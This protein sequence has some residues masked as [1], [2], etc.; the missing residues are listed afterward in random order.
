MASRSLDE[1]ERACVVEPGSTIHRMDRRQPHHPT[2]FECCGVRVDS[3]ELHEAAQRL[4]AAAAAEHPL[5]V[6]LCNASTLSLAQRDANFRALLNAGN[7]NLPDGTPVAWAGRLMACGSGRPVPGPSLM[8]AVFQLDGGGVQHFLLGS[9]PQVLTAL[10][11]ALARRYPTARI[12]GDFSPK[13]TPDVDALVIESSSFVRASGATLVWVGL[14]TPK[15][16]WV[17]ARLAQELG[18]V[19]VPVGAAFDFL[20]GS[21]REAP[22][23]LRGS[24]LEWIFRLATEPRRLWRRYLIGNSVFLWGVTLSG[25]RAAVLRRLSGRRVRKPEN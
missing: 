9:T 12:V 19:A 22:A 21:K 10:K 3:L 24:G 15:Q 8:T 17:S 16:D 6:H 14:G 23:W 1:H 25:A 18:V 20:G 7:L 11:G 13:L 2:S 4:I 5:S